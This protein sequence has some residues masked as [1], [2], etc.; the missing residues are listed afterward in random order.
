MP[1]AATIMVVEGKADTRAA[2]CG[3]LEDAGYRVV[4]LERGTEALEMIRSSPFNIILP[5]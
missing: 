5:I 3:I 2:L 4:G 1:A